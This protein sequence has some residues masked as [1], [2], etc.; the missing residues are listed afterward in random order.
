MTHHNARPPG[1]VRKHAARK[2]YNIPMF[3]RRMIRN[4]L[5]DTITH[6]EPDGA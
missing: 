5:R 1:K 6:P 2:R 4:L 3:F